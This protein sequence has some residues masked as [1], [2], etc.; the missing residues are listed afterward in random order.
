M[1]FTNVLNYIYHVDK[2]QEIT[3]FILGDLSTSRV[4]A[5]SGR[6]S[7]NLHPL[8]FAS[9]GTFIIY[10]YSTIAPFYHV[11]AREHAKY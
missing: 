7:V 2:K 8:I 3:C 1:L 5:E 9:C 10:D 6:Y 4:Q 11:R